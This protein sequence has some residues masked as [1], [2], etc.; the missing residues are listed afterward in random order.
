MYAQNMKF[1]NHAIVV[2]FKYSVLTV[3]KAFRVFIIKFRHNLYMQYIRAATFYIAKLHKTLS[4]VYGCN[5]LWENKLSPALWVCVPPPPL[6]PVLILQKID[7]IFTAASG[8]AHATVFE[9]KYLT[10]CVLGILPTIATS[11][12]LK[13]RCHEMVVEIRP[14]STWITINEGSLKLFSLL[15]SVVFKLL[16]SE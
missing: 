8:V 2:K 1:S 5:L 9:Q 16:S 13:G 11:H 6:L 4:E 15:K 7:F 10:V 14:W 12:D 3:P